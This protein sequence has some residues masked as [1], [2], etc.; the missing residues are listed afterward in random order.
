MSRESYRR[1]Y[2][3][4]RKP[5]RLAFDETLGTIRLIPYAIAFAVVGSVIRWLFF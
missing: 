5:K 4:T 2:R 3:R 1:L